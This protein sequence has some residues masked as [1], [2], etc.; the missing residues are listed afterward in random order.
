[1]LLYYDLRIEDMPNQSMLTQDVWKAKVNDAAVG[2]I[3]NRTQQTNQLVLDQ[4]SSSVHLSF[5]KTNALTVLMMAHL[6]LLTTG[7]KAPFL[8]V[9]IAAFSNHI[10]CHL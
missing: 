4:S 7:N 8:L 9:A 3:G 6:A 5:F 2:V 1:M 10:Y